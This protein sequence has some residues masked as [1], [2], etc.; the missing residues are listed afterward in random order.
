MN[1]KESMDGY[2]YADIVSVWFVV[3]IFAFQRICRVHLYERVDR[4]PIFNIK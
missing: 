3:N 2:G 1:T 4:F